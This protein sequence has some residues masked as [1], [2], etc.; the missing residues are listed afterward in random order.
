M[1]CCLSDLQVDIVRDGQ[2]LVLEDGTLQL[3]VEDD[4]NIFS[5]SGQAPPPQDEAPTAKDDVKEER[6]RRASS[7]F[8]T[9]MEMTLPPLPAAVDQLFISWQAS[10]NVSPTIHT[11]DGTTLIMFIF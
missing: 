1:V 2:S 8:L 5:G 7:S 11:K 4:P 10:T 3:V 9:P 6:R